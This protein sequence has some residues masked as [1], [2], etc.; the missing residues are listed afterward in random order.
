MHSN[1][2]AAPLS[3]ALPVAVHAIPGHQA[4][5]Q[6][7]FATLA[8][9]RRRIRRALRSQERVQR[10]NSVPVNR[11][12]VPHVKTHLKIWRATTS[13]AQKAKRARTIRKQCAGNPR[14][15]RFL[16]DGS[17]RAEHAF[18]VAE[19]LFEDKRFAAAAAEYERAA[20]GY[21]RHGKKRRMRLCRLGWRTGNRREAKG[22]ELRKGTWPVC[23]EFLRVCG[24]Q[25]EGR[26][27]PASHLA[28][29]KLYA[30]ARSDSAACLAH[31]CSA[32]Q[33]PP[34]P[35]LRRTA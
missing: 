1:A 22:E 10:V 26:R 24:G 20:Y 2:F 18:S 5:Q 7:G 8:L 33:P 19:L 35:E 21:P 23:G 14:L 17:A 28:A 11:A 29:E 16:S 30:N 3:N 25:S 12:R 4:Y 31:A 13:V 6:A 15:S 34:A 27:A 9:E 32:I